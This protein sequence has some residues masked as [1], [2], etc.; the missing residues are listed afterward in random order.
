MEESSQKLEAY[1]QPIRRAVTKCYIAANPV[2]A[3]RDTM[4][5]LLENTIRTLTKF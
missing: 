5:G 1:L 2:A 3:V 4:N